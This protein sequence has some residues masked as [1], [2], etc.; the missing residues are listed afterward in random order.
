MSE[1]MR[2]TGQATIKLFQRSFLKKKREKEKKKKKRNR[3][4]EYSVKGGEEKGGEKNR[5][6]RSRDNN[7]VLQTATV[8]GDDAPFARSFPARRSHSGA[9]SSNKSPAVIPGNLTA[10]LSSLSGG[11]RASKQSPFLF[12]R[13]CLKASAGSLPALPC[14]GMPMTTVKSVCLLPSTD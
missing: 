12:G 7:N 10:C 5:D 8:Y 6:L 3:S 2:C 9:V 13:G 4:T 14:A 11:C 1:P